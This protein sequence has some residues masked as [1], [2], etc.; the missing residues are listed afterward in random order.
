M[1]HTFVKPL[2]RGLKL[3][4][5]SLRDGLQTWKRIPT[6]NEK[7]NILRNIANIK[8]V[9][10]VE[11]GSLVSSKIYP[12]FNDSIELYHYTYKTYR[13]LTPY[14]LVP[15]LKMHQRALFNRI[16]NMSFIT[17]VSND[18]QLKNTKMTLEETKKQ[19]KEMIDITP[20]YK[21]IYISC[22]NECPINGIINND[23]IIQEIL[24][25]I[26]LPVQ[27]ICISDTCGTLTKDTTEE[28]LDILLPIMQLNGISIDKLSLHL[29]RNKNFNETKNI[30]NHCLNRYITKFDVSYIQGGG[31]SVTINEDKINDNL[32]YNDFDFDMML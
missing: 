13:H 20:G 22:V 12:Q 32:H 18:F 30:I 11:V 7:K 15:N 27:E 17:S 9:K 19:L 5:V 1:S 24:Q 4:D 23:K 21:K 25:Y 8:N 3:F 28:I 14:L 31:C 29:H 6:L 2:P 26:K 16:C 10:N